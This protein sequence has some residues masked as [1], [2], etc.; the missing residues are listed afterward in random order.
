MKKSPFMM[1]FCMALFSPPCFSNAI[2]PRIVGGEDALIT[3]APWQAFIQ[4]GP[5]FC[6]GAVIDDR[7]VLTA[8]HCI[9]KSADEPDFSPIPA[10]FITVYTGTDSP[11]DPRVENAT[12]DVVAIYVHP[13]YRKG[14]F[15]ND[16]ALLELETPIHPNASP[17]QLANAQTQLAL[18]AGAN[19]GTR[20]LLITGFGDINPSRST[21]SYPVVLQQTRVSLISDLSCSISWGASLSEVN[22]FQDKYLCNQSIGTGSC[23]GDSGGPVV[24]Y[25]PSYAGDYDGGARLVGL[26]SFGVAE[27]C[28]S[29]RYPDVNTQI[30]TYQPWINTCMNGSCPV[31]AAG[32]EILPTNA[33]SSSS[34][35]AFLFLGLPLLW[36][37]RFLSP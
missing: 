22:N 6:G 8:A 10:A 32:A 24:W 27:I 14:T 23:N 5:S 21:T 20:D 29:S 3:D 34:G 11:F 9:D 26:V 33:Q 17:V 13:E 19:L 12:S 2:S 7:W 18:D 36:L 4:L 25:D 35:G 31:L 1:M 15:E 37:R 28:A 16:L 30:A